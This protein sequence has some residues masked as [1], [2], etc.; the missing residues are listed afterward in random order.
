VAEARS[1]LERHGRVTITT[2]PDWV[3]SIPSLDARL[4]LTIAPPERLAR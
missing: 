2:W 1:R 3:T 4:S